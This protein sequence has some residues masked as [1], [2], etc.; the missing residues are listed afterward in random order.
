VTTIA[1]RAA[2]LAGTN[3]VAPSPVQARAL[4]VDRRSS[5][6]GSD[7]DLVVVAGVER[8]INTAGPIKCIWGGFIH[9]DRT[10]VL[11]QL[12]E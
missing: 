7:E 2:T 3:S 10:A 4:A 1:A 9:P 5:V 8:L 6:V 12:Y 11:V